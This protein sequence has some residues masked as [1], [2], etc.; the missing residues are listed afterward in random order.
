MSGRRNRKRGYEVIYWRDIPAQ[1]TA[2]TLSG[3]GEK[4]MLAPRFQHAIDRAA[5]VAGLT[6]TQLYVEQWRR[7]TTTVLDD[8][9]TAAHAAAQQ[10]EQQFHKSR[11]EAI[12][13]NGGLE[14]PDEKEDLHYD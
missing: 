3:R 10:L 14:P 13:K 9:A 2:T 8:A 4:I 12:V 7:E 6:E 1:I 11:L 5:H